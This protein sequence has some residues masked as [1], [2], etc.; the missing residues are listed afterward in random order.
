MLAVFFCLFS[1][2]AFAA[3]LDF[4]INLVWDCGYPIWNYSV[5]YLF[6][7]FPIV[8]FAGQIERDK[9]IGTRLFMFVF[10]GMDFCFPFSSD[11]LS[12][13]IVF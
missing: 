10:E 2:F 13:L 1:D 7:S 3:H 8:K 6:M 4:K 12:L 5:C 9:D 11:N